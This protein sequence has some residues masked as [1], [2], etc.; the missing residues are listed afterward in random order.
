MGGAGGRPVSTTITTTVDLTPG[1]ADWAR[2]ITASKVAAILNVAPEQWESRRS[3][4]L[5]M[6]GDIPW[7]DGRNATEKGRGHYLESGL[8]DWWVDQHPEYAEAVHSRQYVATRDDL[9]WAAA[10]PDLLVHGH[11]VLV[12]AK[13]SRDDAEWGAPGTDEVPLQYLAQVM[14]AMHLSGARVAFIALLTQFL[15]LREYRIEYDAALAADIEAQCRA[16]LDSLSDVAAI[17]PVDGSPATWRAEKRRHPAIDPD[18]TVEL[19]E[20]LA[21][22]FVGIKAAE[23]DI[24]AVQSA[25]RDAMGDARIST[26]GGVTVARRQ[27]NPHGVSLVAVAKSLP[28]TNESGAAA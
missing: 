12:D 6:R 20:D 23:A 19:S 28:T 16:F 24:R 1:S 25:V 27:P 26:F 13:T 21:R 8:L 3:L 2:L 9:P 14:W 18:S 15:D 10:T 5:K 7:D 11:L 17:P 4:W 22:R